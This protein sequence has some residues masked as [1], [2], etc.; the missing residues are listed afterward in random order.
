MSTPPPPRRHPGWPIEVAKKLPDGVLGDRPL[1]GRGC[2]LR[3][4]VGLIGV[5][6]RPRQLNRHENR[7][8]LSTVT[9][10]IT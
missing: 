7:Q 1:A 6:E 5:L 4:E 3:K 8:Q 10:Q 9:A 2:Q